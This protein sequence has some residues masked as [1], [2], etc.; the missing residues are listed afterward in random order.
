MAPF[1]TQL[2]SK[3]Q[4]SPQIDISR[5]IDIALQIY[6]ALQIQR[7]PSKHIWSSR[8]IWPSK[9]RALQR[10]GV[11][12]KKTQRT[13]TE[14]RVTSTHALYAPDKKVVVR[15]YRIWKSGVWRVRE[16]QNMKITK[17]ERNEPQETPCTLPQDKQEEH[18]R[19]CTGAQWM[20]ARTANT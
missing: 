2:V 6:M 20:Y 14:D 8:Y 13:N 18:W 16:Y 10:M 12:K 15:E 19:E 4:D 1:L 9:Y 11:K 7:W 3:C 5:Q 17:R